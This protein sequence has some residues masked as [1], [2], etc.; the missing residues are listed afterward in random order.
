[1]MKT[2]AQLFTLRMYTQNELDLG[3]TLEKVAAIGYENVQ[4]SAVGPISPKR[5]KALCDEN[6]LKIVLTHN[7]EEK[8]LNNLSALIEEHQIYQCKYVG[9]GSIA[10]RYR[11]AVWCDHFAADFEKCMQKLN[12]A[13]MKFMYHHHA[14]EFC[15][16]PNGKTLMDRLFEMLPAELFGVTADTYWLQFAGLDVVDWLEAHAERLSCVHFK[17]MTIAG[18]QNRMA[19]VGAGNMNFQKIW[20]V[21]AANGVTEYVL[22]EQD[23]CYG[24]NPFTCLTTSYHTL[25]KLQKHPAT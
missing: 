20:N 9:L 13:G 12:D 25:E 3:R 19:A 10:E 1:M 2:G 22:V 14:F 6:G 23:D 8:F 16:L 18:W 17:D 21:L 15:R 5:I 4:L 7:A 11:S 24:E